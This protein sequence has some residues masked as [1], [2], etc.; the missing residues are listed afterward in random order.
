[1]GRGGPERAAYMK[2]KM[3]QFYLNHVTFSH[4]ENR[5]LASC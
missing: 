5:P 4:E 1:M 3:N 2:R